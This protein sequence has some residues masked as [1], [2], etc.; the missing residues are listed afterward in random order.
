MGQTYVYT[1][2]GG[3]E[4]YIDEAELT[5]KGLW[6]TATPYVAFDV[7]NYLTAQ[8]V[9]LQASNST[10]PNGNLTSYWSVITRKYTPTP[11]P[12]D[13]EPQAV[14][15]IIGTVR[16]TE[17]EAPIFMTQGSNADLVYMTQVGTATDGWLSAYDYNRLF[18]VYPEIL[19]FG[20]DV[21]TVELG[22]TVSAIDLNWTTNKT[23]MMQTLN[24]G[25]ID[26]TGV[27]TY[28]DPGSFT[29]TKTYTL[30][31]DDGQNT[32]VA[33]TTAYFLQKRYWGANASTSLNDAGIQALSQEFATSRSMTKS[34]T[35]AGQYIYVCYPAA[36][37]T[38]TFTVNGLPNTAWT[39]SVQSFTNAS[40]H[41]SSYNV[42]RSNN[43]LTGT[44]T[45]GVS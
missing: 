40:G 21:G 17:Y 14:S 1:T 3:V 34:I 9:A 45:I 27:N 24:P 44:Y 35:A 26:V 7:V 2:F 11:P 38:A 12:P 5:F 39:L 19:T 31:V 22:T 28:T 10:P 13:P 23:G 25:S 30:T 43:L 33:T 18:Y 15:F 37:G 32:D 16:P 29:T 4:T 8:Y 36:W 41:T 20:N 42:Y 6:L